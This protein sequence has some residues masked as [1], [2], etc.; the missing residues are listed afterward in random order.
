MRG[1]RGITDAQ[2]QE[3][4]RRRVRLGHA[5]ARRREEL[6]LTQIE[7]GQHIGCGF[8]TVSHI[9][10]GLK[11]PQLPD[12]VEW[13]TILRVETGWFV[14]QMVLDSASYKGSGKPR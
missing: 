5:I 13:S 1:R 14:E 4:D 9:E 11:W 12:L 6:R 8:T 10:R 2:R 3:H 7:V